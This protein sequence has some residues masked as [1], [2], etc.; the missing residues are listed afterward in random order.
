MKTEVILSQVNQVPHALQAAKIIV[1]KRTDDWHARIEG[2]PG[3]FEIGK[4]REEAI[5]S[6]VILNSERFA[7][8][9]V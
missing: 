3:M 6:L 1:T 4:T 2:E 5:G 7:I 8:L 9:P